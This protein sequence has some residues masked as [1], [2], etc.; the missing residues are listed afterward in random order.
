MILSPNKQWHKIFFLS[1]PRHCNLELIVVVV[2]YFQI[3]NKKEHIIISRIIMGPMYIETL[4]IY[5]FC[6]AVS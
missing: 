1:S 5:I 6:V 3:E 2:Y 4:K